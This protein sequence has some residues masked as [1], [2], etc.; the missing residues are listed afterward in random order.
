[1]ID[2]LKS[3]KIDLAFC[4]KPS[5]DTLSVPILEQE[6]FLVVPN[7]H[8]YASR[9]EIALREIAGEPFVLLNKNSGLR[10]MLDDTF[11]NLGIKPNIA[12]EA[13]EC[14]AVMTFVS[15]SF[16]ISIIPKVPALDNSGISALKIVH[17][18][19]SRTIYMAWMENRYMTPPVK[20]VKDF[21]TNKYGS[22]FNKATAT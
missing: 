11:R 21:V 5:K 2:E 12:F 8:P 18:P 14:N 17:P 4:V 1:L 3:G 13:E 22:V 6:L 16:G 7:N 20:K 15:M 10:E 19:C 9:Q